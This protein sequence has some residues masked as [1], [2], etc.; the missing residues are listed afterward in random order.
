MSLRCRSGRRQRL[1]AEGHAR[2]RRIRVTPKCSILCFADLVGHLPDL[3]ASLPKL[4]RRQRST[5]VQFADLAEHFVCGGPHNVDLVK[6][7]RESDTDG[8]SE[9]TGKK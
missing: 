4:L 5:P 7:N 6:R 3:A 1:A 2:L 8:K 9:Q